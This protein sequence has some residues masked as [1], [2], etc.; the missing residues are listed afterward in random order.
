MTHMSWITGQSHDL[1]G[2]DVERVRALVGE[3]VEPPVHRGERV[4]ALDGAGQPPDELDEVVAGG[5]PD[6][7]GVAREEV[8]IVVCQAPSHGTHILQGA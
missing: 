4:L 7:L 1:D 5:G 2:G 6:L 8:E 3:L